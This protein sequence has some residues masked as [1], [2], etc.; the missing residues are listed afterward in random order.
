MS[1]IERPLGVTIIGALGILGDAIVILIGIGSAV[2]GV[3]FWGVIAKNIEELPIAGFGSLIGALGVGIGLFF[4]VFGLIG[5]F[6]N[7]KFLQG[8]YWAWAVTVA[9]NVLS[10]IGS[11]PSLLSIF[12]SL[13]SGLFGFVGLPFIIIP[14]IVIYYLLQPHVRAYFEG[15]PKEPS[16]YPP[17]P[18]PSTV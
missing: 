9:L 7:W 11:L 6:I 16:Y 1:S 17:P 4:L 8:R 15:R 18:P 2:L 3:A 12:T 14:I 5:L 13:R 10:V